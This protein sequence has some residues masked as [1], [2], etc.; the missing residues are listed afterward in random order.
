MSCDMF[1]LLDLELAY[2]VRSFELWTSGLI[3]LA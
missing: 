1:F 2:E 3:E